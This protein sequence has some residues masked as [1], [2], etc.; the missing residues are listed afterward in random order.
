MEYYKETVEREKKSGNVKKFF[1]RPIFFV[2]L[3]RGN[4]SLQ[5]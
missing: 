3:C 1:Q 5:T 4:T 2:V